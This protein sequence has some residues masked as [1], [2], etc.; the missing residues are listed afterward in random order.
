MPNLSG[1]KNIRAR[2][3]VNAVLVGVISL[4]SASC[5][6]SAPPKINPS[7]LVNVRELSGRFELHTDKGEVDQA[8][9]QNNGGRYVVDLTDSKDG[10]TSRYRGFLLSP[11]PKGYLVA[12]QPTPK[13][14]KKSSYFYGLLKRENGKFAWSF[15]I[16]KIIEQKVNDK[17]VENSAAIQLANNLGV[18]MYKA[19]FTYEIKGDVTTGDLKRLFSNAAFINHIAINRL[20][21][22]VKVADH[23]PV[24][25]SRP[26]EGSGT[27]QGQAEGKQTVRQRLNILKGLF[28]DGMISKDEYETKKKEILNDL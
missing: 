21:S 20:Y 24:A 16:L 1:V 2:L 7:D 23:R 17:I 4:L 18:D 11:F 25:G 27:A 5:I 19:G 12:F 13:D 8:Q 28:K 14:G 26:V 22:I 9:I 6:V 10:K 15:H 3:L